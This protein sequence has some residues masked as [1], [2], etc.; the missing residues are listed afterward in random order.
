MA[1]PTLSYA[2]I[3]PQHNIHSLH[4]THTHTHTHNHVS[5]RS[6]SH[7]FSAGLK[8]PQTAIDHRRTRQGTPS[9][10]RGR[11]TRGNPLLTTLSI[12][13]DDK[14]YRLIQ[15]LARLIAWSLARQGDKDAA[16][17]WDGLKGGLASGRKSELGVRIGSGL[18][19]YGAEGG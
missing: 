18:R 16:L 4:P 11:L 8:G 1:R 5:T 15:Y 14:T 10:E 2:A 13:S 17:R 19:D 12:L 6:F 7:P 9:S 3:T